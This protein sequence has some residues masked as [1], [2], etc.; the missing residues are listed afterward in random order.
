MR[1]KKRLGALGMRG[2]FG[3]RGAEYG[4]Q[5]GSSCQNILKDLK[6][7]SV[8]RT[9]EAVVPDFVKAAREDMLEEPSD[10]LHRRKGHSAK[11]PGVGFPVAKGNR[12]ISDMLDAVVGEGN[13]VDIGS[14][15]P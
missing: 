9:Q 6:R 8:R 14:K 13:S 3:L 15:I 7:I 11:A 12:C 4:F 10:E 1:A 2:L 5:Y